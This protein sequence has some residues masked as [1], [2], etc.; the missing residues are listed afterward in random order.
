MFIVGQSRKLPVFVRQNVYKDKY[1]HVDGL[2]HKSDIL[3]IRAHNTP[4]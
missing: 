1:T 3:P 2:V 4:I